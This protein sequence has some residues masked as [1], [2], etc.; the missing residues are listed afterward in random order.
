VRVRVLRTRHYNASM[1]ENQWE[2]GEAK[3][4][5]RRWAGT[6]SGLLGR[7]GRGLRQNET[8]KCH[9]P[10]TQYKYQLSLEQT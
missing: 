5:G 3:I 6:D 4:V 8:K 1:N 7:A 9:S 2:R 10:S